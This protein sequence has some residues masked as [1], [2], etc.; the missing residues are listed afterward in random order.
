MRYAHLDSSD[1][2]VSWLTGNKDFIGEPVIGQRV[3]CIVRPDRFANIVTP[4]GRKLAT[5]T[6]RNV[7]D[8]FA[9]VLVEAPFDRPMLLDAQIDVTGGRLYVSDYIPDM[10][11]PAVP[12]YWRHGELSG[13]FA[14]DAPLEDA[15][16]VLVPRFIGEHAKVEEMARAKAD[17][18]R[19]MVFKD[20]TLQYA[21]SAGLRAVRVTL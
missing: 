13:V 12:G 18:A 7:A 17:G 4:T 15:N 5:A 16:I 3:L 8:R 19:F 20:E 14:D 9:S 11:E 2:R 6:A 10:F 21:R 1:D